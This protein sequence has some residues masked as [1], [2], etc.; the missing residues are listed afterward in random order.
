MRLRGGKG[1]EEGEGGAYC[2]GVLLGSIVLVRR[3]YTT[4]VLQAKTDIRIS[5]LA[6]QTGLNTIYEQS[7]TKYFC[8][9]LLEVY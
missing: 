1:N 4:A 9:L 7:V 3:F 5:S 8:T 6:R 2:G